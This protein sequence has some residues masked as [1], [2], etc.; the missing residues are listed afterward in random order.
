MSSSMMLPNPWQSGQAPNGLLNENSR[1]CGTSYW[2]LHVA[3][4][5]PFAEPVHDRLAGCLGRAVEAGSS[6]ANAAPPPSVVRGFDRIGQPRRADLLDLHAIDDDL[7]GAAIRRAGG[8]TSSSVTVWPSTNRRP[9][10][11]RRSAAS[12]S[13]IGIHEVRQRRAAAPTSRPP[14]RR[15]RPPWLPSSSRARARG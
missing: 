7:Q 4:L 15:P 11:L 1:G 14:A 2:M 9:N 8:S 10:P 13:A 3:A 12:V 5:E 6:I